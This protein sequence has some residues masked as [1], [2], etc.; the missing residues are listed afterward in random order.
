M[1]S[2][3]FI[4]TKEYSE[5]HGISRMQTIRLIKAGKI[6]AQRVGKN[7]LIDIDLVDANQVAFE[8]TTSLQKWNK[9]I[10]EKF[11]RSLEIEKSKDRELIYSHLHG[12]GLPHERCLAFQID[13]F[14]SKKEFEIAINRIGFPYWISAVPNPELSYLNRLSK[15]RL[16]DVNSGWQF[17]NKIPEKKN[18]K[19][20]VSQYPDN[21][22]FK[23][24]ALISLNGNGI[25]EFITGDRHYILTRGFILADPMLFNQDKIIRFSK[26]IT[27]SEQRELYNLLRGIYG[28]LEF[29]HGEIDNKRSITFF[30]YNKEE[31]YIE[32]DKIW[33]DLSNCFTQKRRTDKKT[34]YGLPASPGKAVGRCVVLHHETVGMFN[35]VQ[36]GDIIISDTTTPEMTP[37]MTK[38]AAIVTDLGGVTSHAAIVCRELKIPAIVGTREATDKFRTGQRVQ[39]DADKGMIR[40]DD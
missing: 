30:D 3:R 29:Q 21:P 17:V 19:I 13:N 39:V 37:I 15:L 6:S 35:K 23:G 7:W 20:I 40:L 18:Y 24:T 28:H 34:I 4:S 11:N 9:I 33:E 38:A 12:I 5:K 14:P 32:I 25:V 2:K 31:A 16:Y 1:D 36:K 27:V 8:K 10:R 26:T 22:D